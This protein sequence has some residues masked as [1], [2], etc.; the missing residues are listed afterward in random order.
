MSILKYVSRLKRM[1]DLIRR[2]AT[3]NAEQFATRL[4]ISQS[5]LFQDLKEI[6]ELGA[7]IAFDHVAQSYYYHKECPLYL[8][9]TEGQSKSI[10]GGKMDL[11]RY[12][13]EDF[14]LIQDAF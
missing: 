2:R 8:H 3:G 6:K 13:P 14:I 5:Q 10:V 7:P 9:F 12:G 4:G 1:D 11:L